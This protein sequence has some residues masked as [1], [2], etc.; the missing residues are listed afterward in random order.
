VGE[1]NSPYFAAGCADGERDTQL[2]SDCPP[3]AAIGQDPEREWS[4][5]YKR[6]Y[7]RT[8]NPAPCP[9]DGSCRRGRQLGEAPDTSRGG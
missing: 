4:W 1:H 2:V 7:E 9:C 3:C 8:F 5:M 6:G